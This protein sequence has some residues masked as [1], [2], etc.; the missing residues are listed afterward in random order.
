M[1][2][3]PKDIK[4]LFAV[5]H[6]FTDSLDRVTQ[7]AISFL[8]TVRFVMKREGIEPEIAKLLEEAHD[9]FRATLS[10]ED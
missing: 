6:D 9:R 5:K 8:S 4:P 7:E 2:R 3:K 10:T 1:A